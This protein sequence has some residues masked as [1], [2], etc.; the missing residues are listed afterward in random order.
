MFPAESTVT[1]PGSPM[2]AFTPAI[3]GRRR[4]ARAAIVEITH[5]CVQAAG[6]LAHRKTPNVLRMIFCMTDPVVMSCVA[7]ILPG[8]GV[9]RRPAPERSN[10]TAQSPHTCMQEH[11]GDF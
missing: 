2:E 10:R 4:P 7:K 5:C 9:D 6:P 11:K 1:P 3:R 8:A